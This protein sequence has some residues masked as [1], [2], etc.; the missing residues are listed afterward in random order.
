MR[1][2]IV[3]DEPHIVDWLHDLMR[4]EFPDMDVRK[5][6]SGIQ[7]REMLERRRSSFSYRISACPK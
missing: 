4:S 6:Y 2:L 5:A 7:A 1:L 3:D